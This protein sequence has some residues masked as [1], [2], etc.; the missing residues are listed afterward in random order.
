MMTWHA[1]DAG[2][3]LAALGWRHCYQQGESRRHGEQEVSR[4]FEPGASWLHRVSKPRLL[5]DFAIPWKAL[6]TGEPRTP[7][8]VVV[9]R[10]RAAAVLR[11]TL[12]GKAG[13][14]RGGGMHVGVS[15]GGD[16]GG[17]R[18]LQMERMLGDRPLSSQA[19]V[20]LGSGGQEGNVAHLSF[21]LFPSLQVVSEP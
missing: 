14:E 17:V 13:R 11:R 5:P 21:F 10:R 2:F 1:L 19:L 9:G 8:N 7:Q 16:R 12:A 4:D 20:G 15:G 18:S 6:R 3:L